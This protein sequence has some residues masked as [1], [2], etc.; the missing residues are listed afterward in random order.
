M[1][2]YWNYWIQC[3]N[4]P[5]NG[6]CDNTLIRK[7]AVMHNVHLIIQIFDYALWKCTLRRT[8]I[9][10]LAQQHN[11]PFLTNSIANELFRLHASKLHV[12]NSLLIQIHINSPLLSLPFLRAFPPPPPPF[13]LPLFPP[14]ST[15][16]QIPPS[17]TIKVFYSASITLGATP[18]TAR[19]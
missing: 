4:S 13:A 18:L 1:D 19:S 14:S 7:T 10:T 11:S 12:V 8:K 5:N 6:K 2:S 3:I 17:G 15:L 16:R 9:K